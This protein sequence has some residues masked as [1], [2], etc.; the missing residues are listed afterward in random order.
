[1]GG[2]KGL[3]LR[4]TVYPADLVVEIAR[5]VDGSFSSLWF[6]SVAA[7][8]P[9][10]L[11]DISLGVTREL[12]AATG[13]IRLH[14]Y[15]PTVLAM[16]VDELSKSHNNRFV[17]GVGTGQMIGAHAIEQLL[18][19]TAKV[20]SSH[21]GISRVSIYF[22]GL[23]PKM[24][25]AAFGAADGVLLNFCSPHYASSVTS[26][27]SSGR[28]EGFKVACYVKLFFAESDSDAQAMLATEFVHY[29]SMPQYHRMFKSMGITEVI[30]SFK[31]GGEVAKEYLSR[32]ISEISLANPTR[33]EVL[34]LLGRFHEAGVDTPIVYP[35]VR[36]SDE[37]KIQVV[38]M[39]RDWTN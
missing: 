21:L 24:V 33:A 39:L 17:L 36:G 35:Y 9:L 28:V 3:A 27:G 1:M 37:Y 6:P 10:H 31:E 2:S 16:R 4:S 32:S 34:D 19:L 20:R 22:A 12:L 15:N 7:Q 11:C 18:H 26:R 25:S 38:R 29:D 30:K 13:V 5:E 14:E 8:D 23:G